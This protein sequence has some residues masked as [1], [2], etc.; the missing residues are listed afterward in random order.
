[1]K[2]KALVLLLLL[3]LL[4]CPAC[5]DRIGYSILDE[6]QVFPGEEEALHSPEQSAYG[7]PAHEEAAVK[8]SAEIIPDA[9]DGQQD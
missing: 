9:A 7:Q 1:M 8:V 2:K 6:L 5:A 4:L 3:S